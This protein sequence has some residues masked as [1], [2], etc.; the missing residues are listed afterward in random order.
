[1][2]SSHLCGHKGM[3]TGMHYRINRVH[4]NKKILIGFER[5]AKTFL[6]I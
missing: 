2:I 5:R 1:M 6:K 3:H 4:I